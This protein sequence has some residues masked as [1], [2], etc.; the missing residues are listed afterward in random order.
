[1]GLTQDE[2]HAIAEATAES[3]NGKI[4]AKV[5]AQIGKRLKNKFE[6]MF[7]ANCEDEEARAEMR[8]DHE[9]LRSARLGKESLARK[10]YIG[11]ASLAAAGALYLAAIGMKDQIK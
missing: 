11:F 3:L 6:L 1:M 5:E 7:G 2:I 4:D 10:I 8:K 9:F